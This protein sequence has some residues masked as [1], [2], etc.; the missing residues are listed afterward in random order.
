MCHF[1]TSE[2]NHFEKILIIDKVTDL[3]N[4]HNIIYEV[5]TQQAMFT[6]VYW[7]AGNFYGCLKASRN[8]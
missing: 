5:V 7:P 4:R 3:F 2:H 6:V 8:D 1:S